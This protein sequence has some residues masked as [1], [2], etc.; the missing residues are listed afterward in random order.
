[1][2]RLRLP[3]NHCDL[4]MSDFSTKV[5]MY[6]NPFT[7][8]SS[9]NSCCK[10]EGERKRG[11]ERRGGERRG[12]RKGEKGKIILNIIT[13]S[14]KQVTRRGKVCNYNITYTKV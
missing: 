2:I 1:M 10:R 6:L 14:S 13:I 3:L 12:E 9:K 5:S 8:T 7:N 4:S 11:G